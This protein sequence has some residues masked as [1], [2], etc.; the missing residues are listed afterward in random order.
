MAAKTLLMMC[1][2]RKGEGNEEG[3][4][5]DVS[6]QRKETERGETHEEVEVDGE[7]DC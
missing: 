3:D 2:R 5:A 7:V 4:G 6:C 1:L